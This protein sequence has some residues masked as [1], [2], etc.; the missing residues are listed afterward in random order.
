[1]PKKE[2][3]AERARKSVALQGKLASFVEAMIER[4]AETSSDD[5]RMAFQNVV[6]IAE[7]VRVLKNKTTIQASLK[8]PRAID[9][10]GEKA[11]EGDVNAARLLLDICSVLP[12]NTKGSATQATQVNVNFPTLRDAMAK[13]KVVQVDVEK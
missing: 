4:R 5:L 13:E 1:M 9:A 8:I 3:K 2:K 12:Q 6:D 11:A 10:L 7:Y